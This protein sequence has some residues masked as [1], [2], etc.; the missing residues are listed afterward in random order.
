MEEDELYRQRTLCRRGVEKLDIFI[1]KAFNFPCHLNL[2][3]Q[4]VLNKLII[5]VTTRLIIIGES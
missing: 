1:L 2:C 3:G 5:F 4:Y